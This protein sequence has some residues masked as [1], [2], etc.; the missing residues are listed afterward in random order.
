[1]LKYA[2]LVSL[3]EICIVVAIATGRATVEKIIYTARRCPNR[4]ADG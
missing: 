3:I 1:V 4:W 2:G